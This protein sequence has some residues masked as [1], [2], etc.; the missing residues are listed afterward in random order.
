MSDNS[1]VFKLS[2]V[3]VSTNSYTLNVNN[4]DSVFGIIPGS[5][6]WLDSYRPLFVQEVDEVNRKIILTESW[7]GEDALNVPATI[8][9]FPSLSKHQEAIDSLN[10]VTLTAQQLLTRFQGLE[11]SYKSYVDE[12]FEEIKAI[13]NGA[14]PFANKSQLDSFGSPVSNGYPDNQIWALI[15]DSTQ[16]E[17]GFYTWDSNI[18]VKVTFPLPHNIKNIV[19][20]ITGLYGVIGNDHVQHV[21]VYGWH[22]GSGKGGGRFVWD[23]NKP[24]VQHNGGSVISPTVPF[25]A[26]VIDYLDGIGETAPSNMWCWVRERAKYHYEFYDFGHVDT[27]M[28][29]TALSS[30]ITAAMQNHGVYQL[31]LPYGSLFAKIILFTGIQ[32]IGKGFSGYTNDSN[33]AGSILYRPNGQQA[34]IDINGAEHFLIQDLDI[35]GNG[36]Q[37]NNYGDCIFD[38]VGHGDDGVL[39]RVKLIGGHTGLKGHSSKTLGNMHLLF[40]VIR[41]NNTGMRG[42]RDSCFLSVTL[43]ANRIQGWYCNE[44]QNRFIGGFVE[45]NR[46]TSNEAA[47]GMVFDSNA[48]EIIISGVQYDRNSGHD[49]KF[50]SS[51]DKEAEDINVTACMFKGSAWGSDLSIANRVSIFASPTI[52]I[53]GVSVTGCTFQSRRHQPS[54]IA[55]PRSPHAPCNLADAHGVVWKNNSTVSVSNPLSTLGSS[56]YV[57]QQSI[58]DS[59]VYYLTS[60]E[61]GNPWLDTPHGISSNFIVL[62]EG[63]VNSLSQNEW[64]VGDIDSL[65]FNTIYVNLSGDDATTS[66]INLHYQVNQEA[67]GKS[68]IQTDEYRDY[69]NIA[70]ESQQTVSVIFKTRASLSTTFSRRA[71]ILAVSGDETVRTDDAFAQYPFIVSRSSFDFGM[72]VKYGNINILEEGYTQGWYDENDL[73]T[74]NISLKVLPSG[75]EVQVSFFNSGS[76]RLDLRAWLEW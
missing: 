50:I 17:N 40:V 1:Y 25:S 47:H 75:N 16:T 31:H 38:R 9:P 8:V 12:N 68:D 64:G 18:W 65:G 76:Y 54:T 13:Q 27:D 14:I 41:N 35:Q 49:I 51:G 22:S 21:W 46:S 69:T 26:D 72:D 20:D 52:Q 24:R 48:N 2:D 53:R 32:I 70:V 62:T 7:T 60:D 19:T 23:P 6:L 33:Q 56:E 73:K 44:G 28:D 57:W 59:N 63:V 5:M 15:W 66:N 10:T 34:A 45:W 39:M 36:G 30:R 67:F 43:S 42:M 3:S 58:S 29:A 37:A 61:G 4:S 74:L 11:S 55:G 71:F